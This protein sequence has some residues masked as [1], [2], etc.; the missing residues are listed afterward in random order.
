MDAGVAPTAQRIAVAQY[1]MCE[2]DHPT[3]E[4]VANAV[5][6]RLPMISRATIY[7]TLGR[8]VEVGLLREVRVPHD[9]SLHYDGNLDPHHHLIDKGSGEIVDLDFNEVQIANLDLLRERYRFDKL[10]V[11]IEGTIPHA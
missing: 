9:E 4:E 11:T 7:N 5:R 8:L 3:A 2:G 6:T 1:V 10:V